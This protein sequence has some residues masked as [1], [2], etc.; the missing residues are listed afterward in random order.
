MVY[1]AS[2]L[3][4]AGLLPGNI[5]SV[6]FTITTLGDGTNVTDF[7]IYLG[8]IAGTTLSTFTT[9]GLTKVYG[10]ATYNHAI[11]ANTIT[12]DIPYAWDGVSNLLL[13]IR[14]NGADNINNAITY[15]TATVGNTVITATTSSA[16][17]DITTTSPSPA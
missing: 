3:T 7:E 8:T 17:P 16:S 12:F 6:T 5:N 10:P 14:Q 2:E 4:S 9:S 13:D 15:Y 1:P 11:G